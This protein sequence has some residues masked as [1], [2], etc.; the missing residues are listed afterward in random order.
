MKKPG[1]VGIL[2]LYLLV[3]VPSFSQGLDGLIIGGKADANYLVTGYSTPLVR[4][5]ATGLNQGWYNT[6]DTHK[7]PGGD[8][9]LSVALVGAPSADKLFTVDNTKLQELQLDGV[10]ATGKGDIPTF[11]GPTSTNQQFSL[12]D[13]PAQKYS[14]PPGIISRIP[15]PV[16]NIGIGLPKGFTIKIRY[17]PS[18]N[19]D[20]VAEQLEFS[21]ISLGLW[22]VGVMHDFKQYIPGLKS[23]PFSMS[24]FAGYTKFNMNL[25]L[26]ES[27]GQ[28]GKTQ[29]SSTTIQVLASKKLAVLTVYGGLGYDISS[30]DLKLKGTYT[31]NTS[32]GP[33]SINDPVDFST[34]VS[35]PRI[36]AGLRLK[37]GP[38]TLHGDYTQAKYSAITAGF[39]VSIR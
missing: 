10:P 35:S 39:G 36:T 28:E 7:F 37:L 9:T 32:L 3:S 18:I 21:S 22:G 25:V 12:K 24:V 27:Q 34:S 20:A 13:L 23:L 30:G 31:F 26:D 16:A 15:V 8:L 38:I 5:F 1:F 6:A 4:A 19:L 2:I 11:F 17:I 14:A 33:T 29:V